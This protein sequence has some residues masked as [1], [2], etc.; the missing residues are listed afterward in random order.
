MLKYSIDIII[1]IFTCFSYIIDILYIIIN[2]LYSIHDTKYLTDNVKLKYHTHIHTHIYNDHCKI[3]SFQVLLT[4]KKF[5]IE[6][7]YR[8][9]SL[10]S[11][12][13]KERTLASGY[14]TAHNREYEPC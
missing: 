10:S 3:K 12:P 13:V 1:L 9:D 2:L 5:I 7:P 11:L 8:N 14:C 6:C 4:C